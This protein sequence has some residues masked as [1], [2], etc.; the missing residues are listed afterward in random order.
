MRR[1]LKEARTPDALG[2]EER[3]VKHL[4]AVCGAEP[5][6]LCRLLRALAGFGVVAETSPASFILTPFGKLLRDRSLKTCPSGAGC[7]QDRWPSTL[8]NV[9]GSRGL[10]GCKIFDIILWQC[11][12]NNGRM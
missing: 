5:T 8:L 7:K 10:T 11:Y 4:A 6:A 3:T 9:G 12:K 1:P 2:D